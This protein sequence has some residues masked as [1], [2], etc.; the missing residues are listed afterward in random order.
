[1][2]VQPKK[3]THL[4]VLVKTQKKVSIIASVTGE[5]I[6]DLVESWADKAW[7]DA[8]KDGLVTDAMIQSPEPSPSKKKLERAI[9]AR[10]IILAA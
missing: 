8:K 3:Y 2:A 10:Q 5:S 1:M 6:L 9:S 4:A 7:E